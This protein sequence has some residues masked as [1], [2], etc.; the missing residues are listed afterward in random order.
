MVQGSKTATGK[1]SNEF[2]FDNNK[3]LDAQGGQTGTNEPI[4][5]LGDAAYFS[6][7]FGQVNV[8]VDDGTYWLIVQAENRAQTE[9]LA[10]LLVENL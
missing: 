1:T 2:G 8:L 3:K 7:A 4:S 9:Q 5:G 6:P 10:K